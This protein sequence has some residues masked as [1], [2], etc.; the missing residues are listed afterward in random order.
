MPQIVISKIVLAG[1]EVDVLRLDLLHPIYGGN[2]FYKLKLNIQK[3]KELG[4]SKILTF[5][6]SHSNHIFSTAAF[7]KENNISCVGVIRGRQEEWNDSPTLVSARQN[8][9][10]LHF[11][12]GEI[13]RK[14]EDTEFV[15]DLKQKFGPVYLIPEGGNNEF[16]VLGC[17][18]ILQ[19]ELKEYDFVFCAC[20]TAA[21]FSGLLVSASAHQRIIGISVLKGENKLIDSANHWLRLFDKQ[22]IKEDDR[23]NASTIINSYHFGGYASYSQE[24]VEFKNRIESSY[25]LPLDHVYTSKLFYAVNDLLNKMEVFKNKRV[26]VIHSGGQQGNFAFEKRYKLS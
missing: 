13:Y 12:S 21:T 10:V 3:A 2:K 14:K 16:G 19:A 11:V 24:L 22:M 17:T 7:C 15:S 4:Y 26:L 8:G 1:R 9:M 20:G 25:G 6:G 18:E 23:L 5:G